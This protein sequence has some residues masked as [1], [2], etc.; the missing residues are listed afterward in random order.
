MGAQVGPAWR[1]CIDFRCKSDTM[2]EEVEGRPRPTKWAGMGMIAMP[3]TRLKRLRREQG[4]CPYC[5]DRAAP[6]RSLCTSC[7]SKDRDRCR[8]RM[9]SVDYPR[10]RRQLKREVF[11][12]YGGCRCSCC[13]E[14]IIE[15]LQIDHVHGGGNAH[16]KSIRKRSGEQ[17]YKWLKA[18]NFPPGFQ[19]LC[20]NCNLAKG[21]FGECPHERL[22]RSANVG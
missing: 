6:S 12:Q 19:V 10:G 11:S 3:S 5:G 9:R 7:L 16:R 14:T 13:G 8:E 17:F 2:K 15:F 22:R 18:N 4:L 1:A 21:A 20:A